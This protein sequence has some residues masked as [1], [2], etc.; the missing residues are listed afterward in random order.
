MLVL[1]SGLFG[2]WQVEIHATD[3]SATAIGLARR[4]LYRDNA[5]RAIP[6][7]FLQSFFESDGTGNWRLKDYVRRMV[8]FGTL[9]LVDTARYTLFSDLDVIVCRNVLIYFSEETRRSVVSSFYDRL[10]EGGY[11]LLGH[12]ETL[13]TLN[14]PFTLFHLQKDLVYRR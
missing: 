10:R 2:G 5:M 7:D 8:T 6:E 11:L 12:A 9:N 1:A 4:G 13:V 3:L 14:T